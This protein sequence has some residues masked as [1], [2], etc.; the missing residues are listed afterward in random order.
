MEV[1]DHD[2]S[3][4]T[5]QVFIPSAGCDCVSPAPQ[6]LSQISRICTSSIGN[7]HHQRHWHDEVA[8][9]NLHLSKM[10]TNPRLSATPPCETSPDTFRCVRRPRYP[11]PISDKPPSCF[12]WREQ[13]RWVKWEQSWQSGSESRWRVEPNLERVR[14]CVG[15]ILNQLGFDGNNFTLELTAT[16]GFNSVY[17]VKTVKW[18]SGHSRDLIFR[19]PI[20]EYPYYKMEC[21]VATTEFVRHFTQIPV[22]KIYAYDSSSDNELGLEWMLMKKVSG[23]DLSEV[24]NSLDNEDHSR[25]TNRIADWQ[26]QLSRIGSNRIGGLFLRWTPTH[27]KFFIGPL[28]YGGFSKHRRLMYNIARGPFESLY[29]FYSALLQQHLAELQDP[30]VQ[31]V[32]LTSAEING[33]IKSDPCSL[34]RRALVAEALHDDDKENWL[35]EGPYH[36]LWYEKIPLA[37]T[38]EAFKSALPHLCPLVKLEKSSCMLQHGDIST[39]NILMDSSGRLTALLD[40]EFVNFQPLSLHSQY[41]V[42]LQGNEQRDLEEDGPEVIRRMNCPP[43]TSD[44]STLADHIEEVISTHLRRIYRSRLQD[45]K[46]PLLAAFEVDNTAFAFELQDK[47]HDPHSYDI[48]AWLNEYVEE[49]RGK[50]LRSG[51][52][53]GESEAT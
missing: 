27:L 25:I 38:I 3:S 16:G 48:T 41:P 29:D 30:V 39:N 11:I 2:F 12:S 7:E 14:T 50:C 6:P 22:P 33:D 31:A 21:E 34:W 43:S 9:A 49:D 15:N 32:A 37:S 17:T 44:W 19:V 24:W 8:N 47:V 26:D 28:V 5:E 42:F 36:N 53:T 40:W 18:A 45:L 4:P 35:E 1:N 20:P 13:L 10:T 52:S 23:S 46:S 51:A